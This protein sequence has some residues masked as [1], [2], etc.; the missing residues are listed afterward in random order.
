[1]LKF[2][3]YKKKCGSQDKTLLEIEQEYVK[4]VLK[5][6]NNNKSKA[7]KILNLDRKTIREKLK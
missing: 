7:A 1:L 2:F 5:S 3:D 6:V 4:G